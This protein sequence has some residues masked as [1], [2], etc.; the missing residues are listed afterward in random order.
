M[1]NSSSETL[2][3]INI[4]H[5]GVLHVY[6]LEAHLVIEIS[7]ILQTTDNYVQ[8]QSTKKSNADV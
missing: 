7:V 6:L 3:N 2:E 1:L 5:V 4:M 8:D